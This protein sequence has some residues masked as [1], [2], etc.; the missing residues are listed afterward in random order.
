MVRLKRYLQWQELQEVL[1]QDEQL[2]EAAVPARG[3]SVPDAQKT[4]NFFFTVFE[5]HLGHAIS[6]FPK[7]S[8]SKSSPQS[9]HLYS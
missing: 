1:L 2:A 6:G 4:E 9:A 7:T 5:L 3:R 8:F